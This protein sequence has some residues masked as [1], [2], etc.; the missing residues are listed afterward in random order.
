MQA[1]QDLGVDVVVA[2]EQPQ[3]LASIMGDRFLAIDL[4]EPQAAAEAVVSH[5]RTHGLDGIVAVDDTGGAVAALAAQAL[6]FRYNSPAAVAVTRDKAQMRKLFTDSGLRQPSFAVVG[7][8]DDPEVAV[9]TSGLPCVVKATGLSASRGVIRADTV[10]EVRTAVD[11]V[12]AIVGEPSAPVVVETFLSGVEVAVEGLLEDC[13]LTVLAVFDK[14]DPLDGP[15]FEETIYVTPSGL[16]PRILGS[17]ESSVAEACTALDL[18]EGPIHAEARI[19]ADGHVWIL[20]VAARSIGGLCARTLQFGAGVSLEQLIIRHA[21]GLPISDLRRSGRASGV[22]MIPIPTSGLF[23]SVEGVQ[24]ANDV[25]GILDVQIT[26]PVN[27]AVH[28]LPEGDRYLGFIFAAAPEP[29]EVEAALRT[30][31]SRLVITIE[32]T[33]L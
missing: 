12:R 17:I 26:L 18:R 25:P 9:R 31:H 1:A 7:A 19:D 8:G 21:L 5:A 6:G 24:D 16:D 3:T 23:T 28:A 33:G 27:T 30:S 11:R 14:P 20:E 15:Y 22:M 4:C 10:D 29:G 32:K 13:K 2:S